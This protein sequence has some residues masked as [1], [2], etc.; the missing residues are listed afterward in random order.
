[1]RMLKFFLLIAGAL[2]LEY[3]Y[4]QDRMPSSV[5]TLAG[6]VNL[7]N[8]PTCIG[9]EGKFIQENDPKDQLVGYDT[10]VFVDA[11]IGFID[12]LVCNYIVENGKIHQILIQLFDNF[13]IDQAIEQAKKQFG[14][15][16]MVISN[17]NTIYSWT[18]KQSNRVRVNVE[19]KHDFDK[20]FGT[21]IIRPA[22]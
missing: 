17:S 7:Y 19:L 1:M 13:S 15:S 16:K 2:L 10:L 9:E 3:S 4:G 11:H 5:I 8:I 14:E 20:K 18:Y 22:S 6:R 21:L 12:Y